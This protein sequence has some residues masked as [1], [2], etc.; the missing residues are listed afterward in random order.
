[1]VG[2]G[3][4]VGTL[5]EFLQGQNAQRRGRSFDRGGGYKVLIPAVKDFVECWS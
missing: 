4:G 2:S 3:V 1:M 5:K